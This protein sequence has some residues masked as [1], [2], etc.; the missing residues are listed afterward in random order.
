MGRRGKNPFHALRRCL[1]VFARPMRG[2]NGR[3]GLV[4]NPYR[5]VGSSREVFIM[6]RVFYQHGFGA[7]VAPG[8]VWRD[9]VDC[10]RRLLRKG[11]GGV[12]V[13]VRFN[14]SHTIVST[15]DDGYFHATVSVDDALEPG[16]IWYEAELRLMDD[17]GD[18]IKATTEVYVPPP[19]VDFAVI[20]DI[21]DTVMHTGVAN[22]AFM[23]YRLFLEKAD[24]RAAFP[25]VAAFYQALY[26]GDEGD[27]ERPL[28]YVSRA[29]W[30]IYEMLEE[31]FR[32]NRIPAGPVLFLREWGMSLTRPFPRRS[33]DH[34]R[35]VIRR[36]LAL[37]DDLPFIMI[38][39][40]G[41]R[42]P[43][44]YTT[45]VREN[46]TR[47][48]AVYIRAVSNDSERDESIKQLAKEVSEAGS[49]LVLAEDTATMA[50]HALSQGYISKEAL[51]TIM[52]EEE[53]ERKF[54]F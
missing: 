34:K 33:K 37:Y 36:M 15:D 50:R 25:G 52:K 40:S 45:I 30:S 51:A 35:I 1:A 18:V 27:S 17:F 31:F 29:P 7:S 39:D 9:V 19:N 5:G 12:N 54:R 32:I 26:R 21:D 24:R 23:L 4:I 10:L 22:K 2:D 42:D 48:K 43:E 16:R 8:S 41:Q 14:D 3:G 28:L 53:K 20:S 49:T 38:G 6:G 13:G 46:P 44:V 47:V 11:M